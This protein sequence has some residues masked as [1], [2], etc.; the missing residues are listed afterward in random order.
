M[1]MHYWFPILMIILIIIAFIG[2]INDRK[3]I[4]SNQQ[5]YDWEEANPVDTTSWTIRWNP[6]G[7]N[8]WYVTDTTTAE[9]GFRA[10]GAVIWRYIK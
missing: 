5:F 8:L 10:D 2:V 3:V 4:W 9:V 6:Y 1:R 7:R